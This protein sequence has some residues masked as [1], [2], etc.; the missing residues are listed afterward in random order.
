[1]LS[2]QNCYF[3]ALLDG[4]KAAPLKCGGS[5]IDKVDFQSQ[6]DTKHNDIEVSLFTA[7]F[8]VVSLGG[9]QLFSWLKDLG[10]VILHLW[11]I[12]GGPEA[13]I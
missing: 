3:G 5:A 6:K 9:D 7:A 13:L 4:P 10:W 8:A 11:S 1:M 2:M 12:A